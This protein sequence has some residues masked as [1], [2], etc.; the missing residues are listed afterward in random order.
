M[1]V[2]LSA[3]QQALR[4][5]VAQVVDRLGPK[6][7][8]DLEDSGRAAKLDAAVDQAGVRELRSQDDD[9]G[10]LTTAVE[11]ALVAEVLG[12]GLADTPFIGPTLATELR[13]IAGAAPADGPETVALTADL[14]APAV[15]VGGAVPA[16]AVAVDAAG[17][18]TA[19]VLVEAAGGYTLSTAKLSAPAG[20][21]GATAGIDLTRPTVVLD[22]AD[23]TPVEGDNLITEEQLTAWKAFGLALATAELVGVMDGAVTLARDY[24]IGREQ[25]GA[26]IGSYQAVQHLLADAYVLMEGSRSAALHA[27]WAVD[28]KDPGEALTAAAIAKAY[29]ARSAQQVTE[30][31]IQVHGGNGNTWEYLPHVYLRRSLV[32]TDLLG[33]VGPSLEQVMTAYRMGA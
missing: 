22:S 24:A 9:G 10:P 29:A 1:D 13:R 17:A 3:E 27:A 11:P 8:L 23:I 14:G 18:A 5:S 32:A 12:K 4:D 15:A 2:R 7:V 20:N 26:P 19:L 21:A 28:A 33:G 25:Y 30:T 6:S 16:R 31:C